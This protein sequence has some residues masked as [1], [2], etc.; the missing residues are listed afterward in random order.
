MKGGAPLPGA[1][2][3]AAAALHNAVPTIVFHG[4]QDGTVA[5][6]NGAA[7]SAQALAAWSGHGPLQGSE[8]SGR[9]PGGRSWRRT[10]HQ[11]AAGRPVLEDWRLQGAGHAWSG[12][13]AAGSYTDPSG[14]DASSEMLRFFLAQRAR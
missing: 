2:P 8:T 4:D 11:N 5:L 6:A 7:V 13:S 10:V 14:P 9:T 1:A 12:G 3:R